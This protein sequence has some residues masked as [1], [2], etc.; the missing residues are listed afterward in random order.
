MRPAC[1]SSNPRLEIGAKFIA[2]ITATP[3]I[4]PAQN[5]PPCSQMCSRDHPGRP[6]TRSDRC[7]ACSAWLAASTA[8]S[9]SRLSHSAIGRSRPVVGACRS[10]GSPTRWHGRCGSP[11]GRTPTNQP[12]IAP[13]CYWSASPGIPGQASSAVPRVSSL[14]AGS[15]I[16]S[17]REEAA[18]VSTAV[19]PVAPDDQRRR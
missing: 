17:S 8:P 3:A 11:T 18:S 15:W 6:G 2:S 10:E 9:I 1:H 14:A 19:S 12:K 13:T 7:T 4:R 16:R 5:R